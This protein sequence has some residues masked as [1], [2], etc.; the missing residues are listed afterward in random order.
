RT[1]LRDRKLIPSQRSQRRLLQIFHEPAV[2]VRIAP[3]PEAVRPRSFLLLTEHYVFDHLPLGMPWR[4]S[5][6]EH[7]VTQLAWL[8]SLC[9]E[10]GS[11]DLA[12]PLR[13]QPWRKHTHDAP[14]SLIVGSIQSPP[15]EEP[16]RYAPHAPLSFRAGFRTRWMLVH[17]VPLVVT[18]THVVTCGEA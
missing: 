11:R 7:Q 16:C 1:D 12:D 13:T 2:Q 10:Q 14:F 15:L 17:A 18:A 9:V 8:H 6:L 5:A 3:D 4:L